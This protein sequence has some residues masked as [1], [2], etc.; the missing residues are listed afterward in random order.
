MFR[1]AFEGCG[2]LAAEPIQLRTATIEVSTVYPR[3]RSEKQKNAHR[4]AMQVEG[5]E[6]KEEKAARLSLALLLVLLLL[7]SACC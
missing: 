5:T 4:R 7:L 6:D 1:S 3:I 2:T